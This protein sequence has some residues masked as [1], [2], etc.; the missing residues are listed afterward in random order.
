MVYKLRSMFALCVGSDL[1]SVLEGLVI[2]ACHHIR[3]S[4]GP[5]V[6]VS[7]AGLKGAVQ[8]RNDYGIAVLGLLH[9]PLD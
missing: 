9:L 3:V 1:Q 2:L 8:V 6:H 4:K 5:D 7:G